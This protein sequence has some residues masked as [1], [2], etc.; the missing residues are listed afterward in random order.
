VTAL[1]AR[2]LG[3]LPIGWLQLTHSRTRLLA[4]LAGVSFA[5]VL[6]LVQLGLLNALNATIV[7]AYSFFDAD[8]MISSADANTMTDGGNVAR[9]W[10]FLA[11]TDEAV[12]DGTGLFVEN[13]VWNRPDGDASL[14]TFGLDP[15]RMSY[16][17]EA[18]R[19]PAELLQVRDS[20][21][22]D[23][24]TRGLAD[25]AADAIDAGAP[26]QIEMNGRTITMLA[27]FRG[28]VSFSADGYMIVSDQTLLRL[29]PNRVSGAPDHI[30][31]RLAPNADVDAAIA[32]LSTLLPSDLVKVRSVAAAAGEDQRY[33]STQRPTGI[34]FGF[35]VVIGILVGLVIVYQVLSTDVADHLR[36]YAT[37]KAIGYP[38]GFFRS[39]ILEEAVILGGLGFVPGIAIS[40][41]LYFA[42]GSAT[43][44]PLTLAPTT[45]VVVLFGTILACAA[46]GLLAARRLSQADPADLF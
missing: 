27:T 5:N 31:L 22:L 41:G 3:R 6:V 15:A 7:E 46:S 9:Q 4:A 12:I 8:I 23:R 39:I 10:L 33:Q 20:A 34:I 26:L 14:Q 42:L 28:G 18:L 36:E 11:L 25:E 16:L 17:R 38:A 30:L 35:G 32:R 1:L 19:E 45:A 24:A 40:L 37:F 2:L 29:F 44:L 13:V 21:A 43:G